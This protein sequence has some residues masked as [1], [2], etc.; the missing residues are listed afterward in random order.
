MSDALLLL[1][2]F[3]LILLGLTLCRLTALDR[4]VWDGVERLVYHVLFPA[5]LFASILNKPIEWTS[6]L[7]LMAGGL[8]ITSS[9]I[10]LALVVGRLRGTD[11][12]LHASGQQIA[13]RMNSYVAL[14]LAE[15]AGGAD[16]LAAMAVVISVTIPACNVAAVWPLARQGGHRYLAELA[17][18]PLILATVSGLA[19]QA[20][21]VALP[22]PV[23][24]TI[25]RVGAP[26]VPLGLMAV[27][28][29]LQLG[30]LRAAPA[31]TT[32]LLAIRH[33]ALPLVGLA[34]AALI[35]GLTPVQQMV[36]VGF[37]ALPTATSAYVLAARMGGNGPY[38]AGLVTVSTLLSMALLPGAMALWRAV[39]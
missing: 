30:S 28:A 18:N 11:R 27:G 14:A 16:G 4:K 1:P 7:P 10:A 34:C 22:E 25:Q 24:A 12:W 20:L 23:L 37:G 33:I 13:F 19:F 29:G 9:G 15:R 26:A 35:P 6:A 21:G 31:L 3:A 32:Q 39:G 17:R 2:D 36:L 8:M 38:V 5:L